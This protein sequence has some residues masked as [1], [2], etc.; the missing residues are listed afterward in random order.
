MFKRS[1]LPHIYYVHSS[2]GPYQGAE[3]T[4]LKELM[5]LLYP[6]PNTKTPD[7]RAMKFTIFE[8]GYRPLYYNVLNK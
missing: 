3:E 1:I 6:C 4:I 8:R 2:P 7:L 5:H